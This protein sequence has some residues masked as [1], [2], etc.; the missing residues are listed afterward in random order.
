MRK[1]ILLPLILMMLC[2]ASVSQVSA[3]QAVFLQAG[4]TTAKKEKE[5]P[6]WHVGSKGKRYY[7]KK[8]GKRAVGWKEIDGKFYFFKKNGLLTAKTGWVSLNGKRYYIRP[9]RT[10]C[11]GGLFQ[12]GDNYY[13]FNRGGAM[14]TNREMCQI[15]GKYYNIDDKGVATEV[16]YNEVLCLEEARKFINK[17]SNASQTNQ[18]KL[19]SS[20]NYLLAY[21][22]YRPQPADF[23]QFRE[24][25]W[26]YK[27]AINT[28]QSP[29]LNGNCYSF[30]CCVAACAKVLGYDPTVVVITAD[31]GFV[32]IDGLYYD[33]MYG[34]LFGSSTSSHPGY[35]VYT[36]VDF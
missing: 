22:H 3:A 8:N 14:V 18:Q 33:N 20:F 21:M 2:V 1:R 32:I 12:V 29:T 23:T 34:G 28:F 4:G 36:Q 7:I 9:D 6:G 35:E 17:H 30:A 26:Y 15:N 31:H 19:R 10:R 11:E 13:Y 24:S 25:E 27:K 16:S 5:E